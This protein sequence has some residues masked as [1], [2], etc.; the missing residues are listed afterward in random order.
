MSKVFR[1]RQV[2][3]SGQRSLVRQAV[4]GIVL[5]EVVCMVALTCVSIW[6]ERRVRLHAVDVA[7]EG[8]A[9]S[10]FGAV[11][12]AEDAGDHVQLDPREMQIPAE[13]AFAVY[14][15]DGRRLGASS[16]APEPLL[17]FGGRAGLRTERWEGRQF[18]VLHRT[19]LRIIDRA[20]SSGAGL[21]RP[22]LIVY[23][24]PLDGIWREILRGVG[25]YLVAGLLLLGGT[26]I[27]IVALMRRVLQPLEKLAK[28]AQAVSPKQLHFSA[29]DQ[30]L[31]L[32]ELRPLG[33]A[34]M[35]MVTGLR[36][37]FDREHQFLGDA[38]HELKTAVAVVRSSLQVTLLRPRSPEEYQGGLER[39]VQDNKRVEDLIA[40]MLLMARLEEGA[41]GTQQTADV[42]AAVSASLEA[43]SSFAQSVGVQLVQGQPCVKLEAASQLH[44]LW[45][46]VA[47]EDLGILIRN[48]VNNAVEHSVA[49][50]VVRIEIG[51]LDQ[52]V[53]LSVMDEGSGIPE[54]ALPYIFERFYRADASRARG[55][56]GVGLGLSIA[57][58]IVQG[59][60]GT[61]V[62]KSRPG[63]G[64][65]MIVSLPQA[66]QAQSRD[67]LKRS[68]S[69][70]PQVG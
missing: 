42:A 50:S 66:V 15:L 27:F 9:D 6:H 57:R 67:M 62:A 41:G 31:E 25:F 18:R 2:P 52:L 46:P 40:R 28:A 8:R 23:A 56:G 69:I 37:A 55:T 68:S 20:E 29:P 58:A 51:L 33:L 16:Q 4:V 22:V 24:T 21:Q 63:G 48:L 17:I 45:V 26:T 5:A 13:D 43:L 34:L 64:T 59:G 19:N 65:E 47:E 70:V 11:Q 7:L 12:D 32:V 54:E 39:A 30:A 14:D 1:R 53:Q 38:A 60:G 10:L 3:H 35:A 61:I 49:G 44:C 36:E